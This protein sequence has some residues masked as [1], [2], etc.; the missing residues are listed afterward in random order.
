MVYQAELE[1]R[2]CTDHGVE[3][4]IVIPYYKIS[5]FDDLL[6]ALSKQTNKNFRVY[7]G[8][9]CSSSDPSSVID[10][11]HEILQITYHRFN[12]R[13]GNIHLTQQWGRCVKLVEDETWVW[14]LPD[15]DL[16]ASN[17]VE[18][19]YAALEYV[20]INN[21]NVLRLPI[22]IIDEHGNVIEKPGNDP[23]NE[24]LTNIMNEPLVETNYEFYSRLV[25]GEAAASLGDNIFRRAALES[26]GGFIEFP[27]GWGS[28]H[29]TILNV[30]AGGKI[31]F[32]HNT[33]FGFR[34]SGENISSNREDGFEK[35]AARVEFAHWLKANEH[36]F[37]CLPDDDFYKFFY[38]KGEYYALHHFSFSIKLWRELYK[39]RKLCVPS[40]SSLPFMKLLLSRLHLLPSSIGRSQ[41]ELKA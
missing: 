38:W 33:S 27:K 10:Q 1:K 5:Y 22:K 16:P 8:D 15:D 39:L 13:L 4:A 36:I 11:Y 34:M 2:Q 29:A 23:L 3:L 6:Y 18:E 28:D 41:T 14:V 7:I 9:D 12:E 40:F 32:L 17:T 26:S 31:Y 25:R 21:I 35:M 37:P 19:F 20:N 30:A 24:S